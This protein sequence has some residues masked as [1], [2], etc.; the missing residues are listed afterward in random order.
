M[1]LL[2]GNKPSAPADAP[3]G[4]ARDFQADI[5]KWEPDNDK[6]TIVHKFE[7]E[8]F[9]NGSLLRVGSGMSAVFY[10]HVSIGDSL[11]GT[12]EGK[13]Q[14]S[15]FGSG[16]EIRLQTGDSR[17]APFKRA[18][19]SFTGGETPFH[20]SVYF[21]RTLLFSNLK[22]EVKLSQFRDPETRKPIEVY[23]CGSYQI[24]IEQR[25]KTMSAV[26]M[27]KFIENM[28]G[29]STNYTKT[30]FATE[31]NDLIKS[32]LPTVFTNVMK[33]NHIS[34]FDAVG[35]YKLFGEEVG[36]YLKPIFDEKGIT[37]ERLLVTDITA[38]G[39]QF[40]NLKQQ[41]DD[42]SK[43]D[44]FSRAEASRMNVM[45]EAEALKRAREGYTYQQEQAYG[46]LGQAASNEGTASPFMG[47]G[48][49]L[50]MGA[51]VGGAFGGGMGAMAQSALNP[52]DLTKPAQPAAPAAVCPVCK[53]PVAAGAK[54]CNSCGAKL[55]E[56]NLCPSCG[57]S[58]AK[59]S[60]FCPECGYKLIK[61]CP[62]CG[63]EVGDSKFCP[64][65]GTA[66]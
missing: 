36:K 35:Q 12:G 26:Q 13:A 25:D 20:S 27:R 63:K 29:T 62:N 47:I 18:V 45:S 3:K 11:D 51:A 46:V 50:G 8:D 17:F 4:I 61:V 33:E 65:C 58:V 34:I 14:I 59:G 30:D 37:L 19:N 31:M 1:S 48:M 55:I 42:A 53:A 41:L 15:V 5:I 40:E 7:A 10:N 9:L 66:L 64:D 60:K 6:E 28:V 56:E 52:N 2:F 16:T 23:S 44:I 54:F 22:W 21:V 38:G 24:S 32:E 57:K 43:M 39:E 49:G